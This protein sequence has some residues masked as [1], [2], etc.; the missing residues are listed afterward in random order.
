MFEED[1][2]E[3]RQSLSD[4]ADFLLPLA[5]AHHDAGKWTIEVA[6]WLTMVRD[7]LAQHRDSSQLQ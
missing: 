5:H 6:A 7:S 2:P 1:T 3:L 4:A